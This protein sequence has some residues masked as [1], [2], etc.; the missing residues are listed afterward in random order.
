[1]PLWLLSQNSEYLE[2]FQ[3][4]GANENVHKLLST[5]TVNTK[6]DMNNAV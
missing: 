4:T 2:I 3:V 1:M 6:Y 5:G